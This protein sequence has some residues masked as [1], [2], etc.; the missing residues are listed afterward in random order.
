MEGVPFGELM[1]ALAEA[2]H[3]QADSVQQG[4]DLG[5]TRVPASTPESSVSQAVASPS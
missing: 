4:E 5:T 3:R 1:T 2:E